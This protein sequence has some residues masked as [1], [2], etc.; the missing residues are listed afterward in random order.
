MSSIEFIPDQNVADFYALGETSFESQLE[1]ESR[2][3]PKI[4]EAGVEDIR[5]ERFG[6]EQD[7]DGVGWL[8][9]SEP[10]GTWKAEHYGTPK[11]VL[12]RDLIQ[13]LSFR[14][15]SG[16]IVEIG[17]IDGPVY[18]AIHNFGGETSNGAVIPRREYA[19]PSV[20]FLD[21][22]EERLIVEMDGIFTGEKALAA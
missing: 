1:L 10:Y 19:G 18:A 5:V 7:P 22:I 2:V 8:R 13:S 3:L 21:S 4:G 9:L 14:V 20:A 15:E 11:L 6:K 12:E 16:E 17:S